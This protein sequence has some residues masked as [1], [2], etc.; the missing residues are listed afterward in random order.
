MQLHSLQNQVMPK[1]TLK[2][3]TKMKKIIYTTIGCISMAL[4]A[5]GTILPILPT[6]PF[7]M[8]AVFC[9]AKSSQRLHTWF[10][11]TKLYKNNLESY[12]K[13]E[14][15]TK[16]VKI[17]IMAT[18]TILMTIGLIMMNQVPVGRMILAI[19]WLFHILYFSFAVKT[20][21]VKNA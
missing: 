4:G 19:V 21:E 1:S 5:V 3:A 7:L 11:N 6:V 16:K 10:T 18:V 9:F 2:G 17:K 15:M 8:L 13:G 14:G 12:A 20:C